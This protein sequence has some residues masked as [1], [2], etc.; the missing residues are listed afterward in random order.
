[1]PPW[2]GVVVGN[3]WGDSLVSTEHLGNTVMWDAIRKTEQGESVN[4]KAKD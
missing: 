3:H 4:D 1:M 2:I